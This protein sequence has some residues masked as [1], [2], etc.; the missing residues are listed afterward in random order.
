M[1]TAQGL[2]A[3]KK[4]HDAEVHKVSKEM[5]QLKQSIQN[6]SVLLERDIQLQE[7]LKEVSDVVSDD[8]VWS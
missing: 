8:R 6:D 7:K 3:E 5:S 1:E 2:L 4:K